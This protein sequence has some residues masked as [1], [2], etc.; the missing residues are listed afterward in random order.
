MSFG[1]PPDIAFN[2][3]H[4]LEHGADPALR[5]AFLDLVLAETPWRV[6][7]VRALIRWAERRRVCAGATDTRFLRLVLAGFAG[8]GWSDRMAAAKAALRRAAAD[9]AAGREPPGIVGPG[10]LDWSS[11]PPEIN[12]DYW[13]CRDDGIGRVREATAAQI[14]ELR[15]IEAAHAAPAPA[16]SRPSAPT[17]PPPSFAHPSGA[18]PARRA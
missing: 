6:E 9:V 2:L 4:A 3:R 1:A 18:R 7:R 13:W 12:P 14:A 16:P 5:H 15:R 10:L 8:A 11:G 17:R